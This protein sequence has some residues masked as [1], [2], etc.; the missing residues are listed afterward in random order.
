VTPG[1]WAIVAGLLFALYFAF[2]G[3]EYGTLDLRQLRQDVREESTTVVRLQHLV[4]SLERVATAIEKDPRMQE[5][6]ARERFGMLKKGEFLYRLVPTGKSVS[7]EEQR[8]R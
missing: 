8:E 5:R 1:R 3:G 2:Q 4:D 6:V 7:G